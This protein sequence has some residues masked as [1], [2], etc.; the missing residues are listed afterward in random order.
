MELRFITPD[1]N[2]E[3]Q[4]L[5][6]K[7]CFEKTGDMIDGS[8]NLGGYENFN[9]WLAANV[10]NRCEDT[11][12]EG[13]I[14]SSTYIVIDKD[15]HDKKI[16]GMVDIRHR[17][18]DYLLKYGGHIG[19]SV[20]PELRCMGYAKAILNKALQY[21]KNLNIDKVLITCN[22]NNIASEKVIKSNSG[23]LENDLDNNGQ[24]IRRYWINL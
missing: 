17:L 10:R 3:K 19:Y 4:I 16:V 5:E 14:A 6:Y 2:W 11:A 18:N 22:N 15:M 24:I 1:S 21:C 23:I 12:D 8:A 20:H 9:E 7:T 13:M